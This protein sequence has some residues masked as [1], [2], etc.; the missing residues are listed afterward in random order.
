[1]ALFIYILGSVYDQDTTGSYEKSYNKGKFY[2]C[3]IA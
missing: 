2:I 1:M 3:I